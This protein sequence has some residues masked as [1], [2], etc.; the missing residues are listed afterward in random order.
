MP[1][2]TGLR[3]R[4]G[5]VYV[6][7]DANARTCRATDV[8]LRTAGRQFAAVRVCRTPAPSDLRVVSNARGVVQLAWTPAPG[9]RALQVVEAGSAPGRAGLLVRDVG[10]A[11]TFTTPA[12][13]GT[14]H[15]RVR[16]KNKCGTSAAS[17]ELTVVV[18]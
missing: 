8:P 17:S 3:R 13:P 18:E 4:G 16:G 15:A 7:Y 6:V 10:W 11:T 1:H 5:D 9:N 12:N 14:Y 2:P